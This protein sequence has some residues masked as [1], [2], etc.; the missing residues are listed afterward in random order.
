MRREAIVVNTG[1]NGYWIDEKIVRWTAA[2]AGEEAID[3]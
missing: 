3:G 1:S 2:M